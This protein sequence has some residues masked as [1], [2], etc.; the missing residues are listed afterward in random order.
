MATGH[1]SSAL[2]AAAAIPHKGVEVLHLPDLGHMLRM[3]G[4]HDWQ[5]LS[6]SLILLQHVQHL[7]QNTLC[8]VLPTGYT[9]TVH[10]MY[11]LTL[12]SETYTAALQI[13][14]VHCTV[15]ESPDGS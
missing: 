3:V 5:S 8:D 11:I 13:E 14:V 4:T 2:Q 9:L 6:H 10:M 7:P 15:H 1:A 12:G